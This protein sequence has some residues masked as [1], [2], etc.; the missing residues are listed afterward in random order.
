MHFVCKAFGIQAA[1]ERMRV[2]MKTPAYRLMST[3][4]IFLVGCTARRLD[5]K[6]ATT[7]IEYCIR[8]DL[9]QKNGDDK[10]HL[11][12]FGTSARPSAK[13]P[14]DKEHDET[15]AAQSSAGDKRQ[16]NSSKSSARA[17]PPAGEMLTGYRRAALAPS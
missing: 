4:S 17:R 11:N 9:V 6:A 15:P 3:T 16:K 5:W 7:N 12:C 10:L 14:L 1:Q 2:C 13:L 8:A